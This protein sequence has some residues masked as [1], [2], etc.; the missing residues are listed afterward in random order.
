MRGLRRVEIAEQLHAEGFHSPQRGHR[1]DVSTVRQ[2]LSRYRLTTRPHQDAAIDAA[3]HKANEWWLEELA[4]ELK[5]SCATLQRWC[6]KGWMHAHK[7]TVAYR[8]FV[9]WADSR[10]LDRLRQLRDYQRPSLRVPYPPE[11]TT[12]SPRTDI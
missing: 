9:A 7:V 11:L 8:R 12:P 1:F 2:M 10:E 3:L 4:S 6:R 5:T